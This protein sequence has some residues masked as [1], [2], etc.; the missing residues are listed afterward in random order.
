[1][2]WVDGVCEEEGSVIV[3]DDGAG[4]RDTGTMG[5]LR[6]RF[7]PHVTVVWRKGR[8]IQWTHL[9]SPSQKN[10]RRTFEAQP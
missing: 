4:V 5:D 9:E 7:F 10:R 1:M 2:L 3:G 6:C 8:H